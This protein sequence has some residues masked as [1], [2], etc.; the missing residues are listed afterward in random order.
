[1]DETVA[2]LTSGIDR[3][4]ALAESSGLT[5][6]EREAVETATSGLTG[7]IAEGVAMLP[8]LLQDVA[9]SVNDCVQRVGY[10]PT[11][12]VDCERE[13]FE[14]V[15]PLAKQLPKPVL[16]CAI[17]MA[18]PKGIAQQAKS[19]CDGHQIIDGMA[20]GFIGGVVSGFLS[21]LLTTGGI[22]SPAIALVGG[23]FGAFAGIMVGLYESFKCEMEK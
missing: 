9:T 16:M 1:L 8:S 12:P 3:V 20:K 23:I 19:K 5:D 17:S 14:T 21:G 11:D 13:L 22:A 2:Q 4:S 6:Y 10:K 18:A 15:G 7:T